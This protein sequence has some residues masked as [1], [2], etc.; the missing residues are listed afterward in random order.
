MGGGHIHIDSTVG[1]GSIKQEDEW[2]EDTSRGRKMGRV[3]LGEG[4][5]GGSILRGRK[6]WR[7]YTFAAEI[8][9]V[10]STPPLRVFLAPSLNRGNKCFYICPLS[11]LKVY[12]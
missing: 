11:R 7:E 10:M 5:N 6:K 3:Y 9:G 2:E 4:K 12:L 1:G 8:R